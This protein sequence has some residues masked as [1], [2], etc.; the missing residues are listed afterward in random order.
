MHAYCIMKFKAPTIEALSSVR[1]LSVSHQLFLNWN[2]T[3]IS[4]LIIV[5]Q[6][7]KKLYHIS[8]IPLDVSCY[9]YKLISIC[10]SP[11][12]QQFT[13]YNAKWRQS[14]YHYKF[15][16]YMAYVAKCYAL[17]HAPWWHQLTLSCLRWT[18]TTFLIC[19][20]NLVHW[21]VD[22]ALDST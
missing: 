10:I 21:T 22:Y 7:V 8:I 12:W 18:T 14:I 11:W 20:S 4:E 13:L 17:V 15:I 5:R 1:L 2:Y 6:N 3:Q 19:I 9:S 16:I